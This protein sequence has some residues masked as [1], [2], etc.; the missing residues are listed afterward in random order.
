ME[1]YIHSL[2][3][4]PNKESLDKIEKEI[5]K[6]KDIKNS[7][8]E[9]INWLIKQK[10]DKNVSYSFEK[11]NR[12]IEREKEFLEKCREIRKQIQKILNQQ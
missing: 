4:N 2:L 12:T 8:E 1:K 9:I 7:Y 10:T 6:S 5:Q 11:M 3:E